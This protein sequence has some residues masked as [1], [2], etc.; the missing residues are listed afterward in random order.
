VGPLEFSLT[1]VLSSLA[2]P[3]AKSQIS[4][5]TLST[6]DTDYVPVRAEQLEAARAVLRGRFDFTN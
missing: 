1:G 2:T 6:Y 5:F 4:I 3:L